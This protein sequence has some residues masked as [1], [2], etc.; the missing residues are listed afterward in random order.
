MANI[1]KEEFYA[2]WDTDLS[3]VFKHVAPVL[4]EIRFRLGNNA[5]SAI[6]EFSK[7]WRRHKSEM[8]RIF[9]AGRKMAEEEEMEQ[10]SGE[11]VTTGSA[12]ERHRKKKRSEEARRASLEEGE[13]RNRPRFANIRPL[14][15]LMRRKR[16]NV[17]SRPQRVQSA[18]ARRPRSSNVRCANRTG[19]GENINNNDESAK[20]TQQQID[21]YTTEIKVR[22][23]RS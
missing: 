1:L 19:S 9:D 21:V 5:A 13:G 17:T 15:P 20:L 12:D 4:P 16:S 8:R 23:F 6:C 11:Q 22:V 7:N 14:S 10:E 2:N 3:A 18:G